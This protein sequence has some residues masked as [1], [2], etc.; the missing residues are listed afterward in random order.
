MKFEKTIY[1][2]GT[3]IGAIGIFASMNIPLTEMKGAH[4][5][6]FICIIISPILHQLTIILE[7]DEK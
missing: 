6:P 7:K 2:I 5:F 3:I 1:K 4:L